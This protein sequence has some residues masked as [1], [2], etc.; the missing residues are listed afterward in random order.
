MSALL[1]LHADVAR[2]L[3]LDYVAQQPGAIR[4]AARAAIES[5]DIFIEEYAARTPVLPA[6]EIVKKQKGC[7]TCFGSGGKIGQ[8]CKVCLGTGKLPV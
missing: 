6:S 1:N 4:E 8:P 7:R 2:E 5:A 3:F